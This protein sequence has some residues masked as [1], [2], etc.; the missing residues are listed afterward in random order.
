MID[1]NATLTDPVSARLA[2]LPAATGEVQAEVI[3]A[4]GDRYV[5][6]LKEETP[7]GQGEDP[8]GLVGAYQVEESYTPNSA[9]YRI[10][11]TTPYLRYVLNGRG[12]VEA[13]SGHMLRFVIDGE[14]FFR[15]RV[16][17]AA[18]NDFPS[19]AAVQMQGAIAEAR[20]AFPGLIVRSMK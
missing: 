5:L 17:P 12:P 19:R 15:K 16:G 13:T 7:R 8:G 11:N 1:L 3:K 10:T 6:A 18:A 4:L 20:Q 14:V 2:A 9:S